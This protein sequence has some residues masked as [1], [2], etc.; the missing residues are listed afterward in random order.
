M[1]A[2]RQQSRS[3][4]VGPIAAIVMGTAAIMPCCLDLAFMT[5]LFKGKRAAA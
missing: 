5:L 3:I 4:I 2:V 1:R